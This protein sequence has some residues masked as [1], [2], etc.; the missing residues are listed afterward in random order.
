MTDA[1]F[2]TT[3]ALGFFAGAIVTRIYIGILARH[4]VRRLSE[5]LEQKTAEPDSLTMETRV[6][7]INDQFFVWRIDNDEFVG[8]GHSLDELKQH[9]LDRFRNPNVHI[10]IIQ[11][12]EAA[13]ERLKSQT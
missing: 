8:Q 11:G 2:V 7:L 13:L 5:A 4:M 1:D 12:D 3:L 10:K 6:E 9:C